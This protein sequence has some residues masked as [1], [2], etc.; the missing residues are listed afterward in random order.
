MSTPRSGAPSR[1]PR[2][3][4]DVVLQEVLRDAHQPFVAMR[5]SR[6]FSMSIS[7]NSHVLEPLDRDVGHVAAGH[8]DVADLRACAQVVEHRVPAVV[9]LHL[10]L[11]LQDLQRV[12]AD[13]VHPRAVAA[14][15][16]ARGDQ[17]GEHL[18]RVAMA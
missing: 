11:V 14:V 10:E 13:Q 6:M 9:L 12:V 3:R 5:M 2:S 8:D 4:E 18:G 16:R 17:L 7:S 1:S 15:L